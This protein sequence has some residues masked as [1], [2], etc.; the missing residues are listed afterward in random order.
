[1]SFVTITRFLRVLHYS[2]TSCGSLLL[3]YL[4]WILITHLPLVDP[5]YSFTSCG[6]LLLIYLLWILNSF[7]SCGSL[8][9][10]YLLWILI[11]HLPLVDP[12]YSFTSCGSL[13]LIYLLWIL[14]THLYKLSGQ[15][16]KSNMAC[17][18][19]IMS[20]NSMLLI[21]PVMMSCHL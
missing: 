17:H 5:Y 9:L 11:T 1:M 8:L 6:S 3:I 10:I 4:L 2:F 18:T 21:C 16:H 14:I 12:Y 7:T 19:D 13:L 20:V 15:I